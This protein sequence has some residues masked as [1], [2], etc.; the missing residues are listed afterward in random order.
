MET[1][2]KTKVEYP[3][4]ECKVN[5]TCYC[6]TPVCNHELC[7]ICEVIKDLPPVISHHTWAGQS[8]ATVLLLQAAV[9]MGRGDKK[10]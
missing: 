1:L 7:P 10:C 2:I 3:C 5:V 8:Q 6:E 4:I 9:R